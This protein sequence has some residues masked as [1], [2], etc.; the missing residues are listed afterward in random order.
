[1]PE[2]QSSRLAAILAADIAGYSAL[3][4]LD[5]THTVRHL[6]GHQSRRR[7]FVALLGGAV[8]ALP[9]AA[10]AQQQ[11]ERVRSLGVLMAQREDD[12][13]GEARVAAFRAALAELG[14]AEGRNL[15]VEW[16]WTGADMARVRDYA[17]ELVRL[18]PD[19]IL[20]NGTP[21]VAA[22]KLAT[23][24]IPVVLAVVNDPVA[25]GFI[26]S[27]A[28]PG[29]NI[30][31]FSFLEYSMV[32]KSLE[33]LKQ[34]APAMVRVAVMFNPDT[35]PYYNIHLRSFETVAKILG[36]ALSGA[37]VRTPIEIEQTIANLG[38]QPGGGLLVTPDP[39]MNVHRDAVVRA[40]EQYRVPATYSFRQRVQEGGLMSYGAD[41]LDI[42]RRAAS[43]V[44]RILKG[45]KPA[46]LPAQAPVKFELAINLRTARALGLEVPPTLMAVAD[47]VIE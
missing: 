24:T 16:R 25:Q 5:E 2:N 17:A 23:T 43:Y 32:G 44:D 40:A 12:P 33:M 31:G 28:H 20:A 15:K 34:I 8:I 10:R 19:V 41:T 6:K 21:N 22:L 36:L 38:G 45:T 1:V 13:E 47:E 3:T 35:Y 39:Y 42:F 18:S 11:G 4:G 27:M 26:A 9:L 37:P 7:D 14:W 46:D 29:G 30:T